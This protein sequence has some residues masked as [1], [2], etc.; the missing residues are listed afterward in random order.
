MEEKINIPKEKQPIYTK[1]QDTQKQTI[2]KPAEEPPKAV[3]EKP[4]EKTKNEVAKVPEEPITED[5]ARKRFLE[6]FKKD[7]PE[8][9]KTIAEKGRELLNITSMANLMTNEEFV[10]EF[11]EVQKKQ[12]I[13][14]LKEQGKLDAIKSAAKKQENRNIRNAAFYNAFK[15][16]FKNFM[17]IDEHF[18]LI[19]MIVTV[20]IFYIPYILIS[21]VLTVVE[22]TFT[23][24]NN[25]FEAI[26]KFQKPAKA[27][28]LTVLWIVFTIA[29]V[30][31]LLYGAQALF[32]FKII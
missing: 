19:P 8:E 1:P 3:L 13:D 26:T 6:L 10:K 30:L 11:Q 27:L 29:I 4:E 17:G 18:G 20:L 21:L 15:P 16:F 9:N 32:G 23:G 5:E 31:S 7:N 12:I 28:C 2:S 14:D 24:I 25:I 22:Y